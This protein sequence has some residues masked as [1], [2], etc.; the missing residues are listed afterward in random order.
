MNIAI[1]W[2]YHTILALCIGAGLWASRN[3]LNIGISKL[4]RRAA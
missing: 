2:Q 4:R 1:N 3:L